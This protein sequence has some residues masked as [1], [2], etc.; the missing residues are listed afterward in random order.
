MHR[1]CKFFAINFARAV[2]VKLGKCLFKCCVPTAGISVS[3]CNFIEYSIR[4]NSAIASI[5]HVDMKASPESIITSTCQIDDIA[6]N[7]SLVQAPTETRT[8]LRLLVR[9]HQPHSAKRRKEKLNGKL[10]LFSCMR[11]TAC[12]K[13]TACTIASASLLSPLRPS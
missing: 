7:R 13:S 10:C 8:T 5:C 1:L 11:R 9:I 12:T 4:R 2:R 6:Q 3:S